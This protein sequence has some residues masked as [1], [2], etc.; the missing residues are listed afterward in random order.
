MSTS[1]T[2]S[3]SIQLY[4][5]GSRLTTVTD[6]Q[7]DRQTTRYIGNNGPHLHLRTVSTIAI[8]HLIQ[9]LQKSCGLIGVQTGSGAVRHRAIK[10][11][12]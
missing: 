4:L 12:E 1:Q 7:T 9:L 5:H 6:R 11:V 10:H 2:A 3:R 8:T